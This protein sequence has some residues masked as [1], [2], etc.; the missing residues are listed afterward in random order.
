MQTGKR[1]TLANSCVN[2]HRQ[3]RG[4]NSVRIRIKI[5]WN[6]PVYPGHYYSFYTIWLYL[7]LLAPV[8]ACHIWHVSFRPLGRFIYWPSGHVIIYLLRQAASMILWILT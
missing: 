6:E 7:A 1:L 4:Q 8:G 3:Q 2:R 5:Y